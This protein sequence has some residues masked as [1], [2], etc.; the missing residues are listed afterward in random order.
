MTCV[1]VPGIGAQLCVSTDGE[2]FQQICEHLANIKMLL[3]SN[4]INSVNECSPVIHYIL[5]SFDSLMLFVLPNKAVVI[6]C[7]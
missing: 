3:Y 4:V 6:P 2:H 1:P 5:V 7:L